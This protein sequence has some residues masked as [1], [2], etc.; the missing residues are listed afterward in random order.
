MTRRL[1]HEIGLKRGIY[2]TI[3]NGETHLRGRYVELARSA[4]KNIRLAKRNYEIKIANEAKSDPK[5]IFKLYRTKTRDRIGPL[6]TNTGELVETGEDMSQMM[7]EYFLSVFK[8][9]NLTTI[10][11]R[12]QVYEC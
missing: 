9:E 11:L 2:R 10:P 1:K 8:Q 4:K 3:K 7:N 12:V 6:K 5:G